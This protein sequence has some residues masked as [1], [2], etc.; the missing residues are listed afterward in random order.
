LLPAVQEKLNELLDGDGGISKRKVSTFYLPSEHNIS[1]RYIYLEA[2]ACMCGPL[3]FF[4]V[5]TGYATKQEI[6][7]SSAVD[8][9]FIYFVIN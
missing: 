9:E 3:C 1:N 5:N 4:I 7:I 6:S 8:L 2:R